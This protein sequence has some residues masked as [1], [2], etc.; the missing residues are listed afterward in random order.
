MPVIDKIKK[1]VPDKGQYKTDDPGEGSSLV[2]QYVP[3]KGQ[4]KTD[5]PGEG[6]SLVVHAGHW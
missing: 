1:Y 2:V 6:S 5:D 3:D 4:Y